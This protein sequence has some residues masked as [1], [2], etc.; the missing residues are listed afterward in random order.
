MSADVDSQRGRT[1]RR[2]VRT[3]RAI[4]DAFKRLL[5]SKSLDEITISAIAREASIDRKTFYLHFGSIDGLLDAIAEDFVEHVMSA[6]EH[7]LG[8]HG[9]DSV[10][11]VRVAADSFFLTINEIVSQS[12]A[13]ERNLFETLP[14]EEV[15]T[16]VRK[17]LERALLKS[18]IVPADLPDE[19][20]EYYLSFILSGIVGIYRTWVLSDQNVPLEKISDVASGLTLMGLSSLHDRL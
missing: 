19:L 2:V 4:M 16:R 14:A 3:H 13:G 20:F 17:P 15:I 18:S 10:D 11:D 12:I 9:A 8:D 1:D 6:V 5:E 7:A